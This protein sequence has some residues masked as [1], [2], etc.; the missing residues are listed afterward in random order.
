MRDGAQIT[1]P[2]PWHRR[3]RP[4]SYFT[5]RRRRLGPTAAGR[6]SRGS[7]EG[8]RP[9]P[10]RRRPPPPQ[11]IARLTSQTV[12]V[13]DAISPA[14]PRLP[15]HVSLSPSLWV[16]G[17]HRHLSNTDA[18]DSFNTRETCRLPDPRHRKQFRPAS[19][20][21]WQPHDPLQFR[22]DVSLLPSTIS[23]SIFFVCNPLV[24]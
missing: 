12:S 17:A 19:A 22:P 18:N 5:R 3:L 10:G 9:T 1:R 13:T 4:A 8:L 16:P 7:R 23:H 2:A 24:T 6:S 21:I 14:V 15:S 20:P 11:L